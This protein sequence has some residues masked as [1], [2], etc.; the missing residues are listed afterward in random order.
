MLGLGSFSVPVLVGAAL[1]L[2]GMG[3][4][5]ARRARLSL[6]ATLRANLPV[7]VFHEL[8]FAFALFLGLLLRWEQFWGAGAQISH[9]EKPMDFAFLNGILASTEFP[10]QDPWLAHYPI[11]YYYYG[12]LMIAALMRL[13]ELLR[14]EL[15]N[16]A[17]ATFYA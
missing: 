17:G 13:L 7:L 14:A 16:L 10:P 15:L 1:L 11:N 5:A 4:F 2:G 12:Y 8:L 6:V 9:T 3:L